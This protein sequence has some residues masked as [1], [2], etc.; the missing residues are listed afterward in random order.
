[1][2][3]QKDLSPQ[4]LNNLVSVL[5]NW[6]YSGLRYSAK[7]LPTA[8]QLPHCYNPATIA[9]RNMQHQDWPNFICE[10]CAKLAEELRRENPSMPRLEFSPYEFYE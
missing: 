1:M 8:C 10:R 5:A 2:T 9:I 4:E 7:K 6:I 3:Q